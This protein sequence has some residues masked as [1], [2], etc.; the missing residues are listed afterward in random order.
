MV[1]EDQP[2]Q[3]PQPHQ[4]AHDSS[5]NHRRPW[6]WKKPWGQRETPSW[7]PPPPIPVPHRHQKPFLFFPSSRKWSVSDQIFVQ[8]F[9]QD[10]LLVLLT[11]RGLSRQASS[12]PATPPPPVSNLLLNH[13]Y[14][15]LTCAHFQ[16][17]VALGTAHLVVGLADIDSRHGTG[18]VCEA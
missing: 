14:P 18:K 7:S 16:G 13:T 15:S 12:P 10:K 11:L 3:H 5:S 2:G 9:D 17:H 1:Q 8:T 4:S 6:P